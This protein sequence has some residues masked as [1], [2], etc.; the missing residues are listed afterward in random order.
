[1]IELS[2]GWQWRCTPARLVPCT[3]L[4]FY[5]CR[6]SGMLEEWIVVSPRDSSLLAVS[7]WSHL[8]DCSRCSP[9]AVSQRLGQTALI[10]C[11]GLFSL[12]T[13]RTLAE[14]VWCM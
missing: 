14:V 8:S 10:H 2:A 7:G 5:M 12:C 9:P 11:R 3:D 4:A 6:V 1:M 13:S